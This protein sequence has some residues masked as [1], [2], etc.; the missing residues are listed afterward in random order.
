[1]ITTSGS[2]FAAEHQGSGTLLPG[3]WCE[4]SAELR[5]PTT[6]H[7]EAKNPPPIAV[8]M[9]DRPPAHVDVVDSC[10]G[11]CRQREKER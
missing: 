1:M 4:A 11:C 9:D 10:Y 6:Q 7:A 2:T 3:A 8:V 5:R